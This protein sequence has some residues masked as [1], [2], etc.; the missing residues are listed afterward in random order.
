MTVR[1]RTLTER[2]DSFMLF[3][4]E[5]LSQIL[6]MKPQHRGTA[7]HVHAIGS[8]EDEGSERFVLRVLSGGKRAVDDF[9][10]T[11]TDKRTAS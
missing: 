10:G 2:G 4:G 6:P 5:E 11:Q 3:P 7:L 8:V 1:T 9:K